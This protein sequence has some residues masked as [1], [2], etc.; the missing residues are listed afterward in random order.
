MIKGGVLIVL[1]LLGLLITVALVN[2]TMDT[3]GLVFSTEN[4]EK[5]GEYGEQT[6]V[7]EDPTKSTPTVIPT[8]Q[9]TATPVPTIT[10]S[11]P[12]YGG[13][14]VDR[15]GSHIKVPS[16]SGRR[17]M[18]LDVVG[19]NLECYLARSKASSGETYEQIQQGVKEIQKYCE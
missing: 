2:L 4:S 19:D 7:G 12:P 6:E 14:R 16:S 13:F 5:E 15:D 17:P 9:P 3:Y 8:R 11:G 18:I 1:G 10:S